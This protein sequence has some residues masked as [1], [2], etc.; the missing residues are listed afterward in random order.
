[1]PYSNEHR[2]WRTNCALRL[3]EGAACSRLTMLPSKPRNSP[4]KLQFS[5]CPFLSNIFC[6]NRT[7][8]KKYQK[9]QSCTC[10]R[11]LGMLAATSSPRELLWCFHHGPCA[12]FGY[13][14]KHD[15]ASRQQMFESTLILGKGIERS[16]SQT[17]ELC[18]CG[19]T[20]CAFLHL[21]GIDGPFGKLDTFQASRAVGSG[22]CYNLVSLCT[23]QEDH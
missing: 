8:T 12:F 4:R 15:L 10:Q 1:M 3:D 2:V 5:L 23:V 17:R 16:R 9:R 14:A 18:L 13:G 11:K 21:I 20:Q 6:E 7:E 22:A 19:G